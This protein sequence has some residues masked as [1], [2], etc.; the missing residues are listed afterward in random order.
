VPDPVG[1]AGRAGKLGGSRTA[2]YT[3][4]SP[5]CVAQVK[6]G[7]ARCRLHARKYGRCYRHLRHSA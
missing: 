2:I 4:K 5:R 7:G 6:R 1:E 3:A